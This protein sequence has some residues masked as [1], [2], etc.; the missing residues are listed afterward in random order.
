MAPGR[1]NSKEYSFCLPPVEYSRGTIPTHAAKSRP[2]R[3]A[4]PLPIAATRAVAVTG[5][6]PG[7]A[8]SRQQASFSVADW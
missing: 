4:L 3:N 7:M 8:V 2:L 1:F 6:I 5:P